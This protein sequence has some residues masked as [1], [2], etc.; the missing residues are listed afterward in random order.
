VESNLRPDP[1]INPFSLSSVLEPSEFITKTKVDG[2]DVQEEEDEALRMR[3]NVRNEDRRK[4][5]DIKKEDFTGP[6]AMLTYRFKRRWSFQKKDSEVRIDVTLVTTK[7]APASVPVMLSSLS[8]MRPSLEVEVEWI[9]RKRS[10]DHAEVI[11]KA[12][13]STFSIIRNII[14]DMKRKPASANASSSSNSSSGAVLEELWSLVEP[15]PTNNHKRKLDNARHSLPG[16]KPMTLEMHHLDS[17]SPNAIIGNNAITY[18]VTKKA[19]GER[20]MLFI[21]SKRAGYLINDRLNVN[22]IIDR[23]NVDVKSCLLDGELVKVQ[24]KAKLVFMV[25]DAY[26]INGINL[27]SSSSNIDLMTRIESVKTVV[28]PDLI[29]VPGYEVKVKEFVKIADKTIDAFVKGCKS[30]LDRQDEFDNDGLILTP[31]DVPPP[32]FGRWSLALKWKPSD[33]N[34]I[35]F[36]VRFSEPPDI[37]VH[38]GSKACATAKLMAGQSKW[39]SE[40]K[41]TTASMLNGEAFKRF[42]AYN[43]NP[44]RSDYIAVPFQGQIANIPCASDGSGPVANDGSKVESGSVVEF[45]YMDGIWIPMRVRTDK[46][47]QQRKKPGSTAANNMNTAINVWRSIRNPISME[48]MTDEKELVKAV[49]AWRDRNSKDN[50]GSSDEY[51]MGGEKSL[52]EGLAMRGMRDF[53]NKG[54]KGSLIQRFKGASIMDMGVGRVGDLPKWKEVHAK[55]ILGF[56]K[57][58]SNLNDPD[59]DRSSA[60]FRILTTRDT[61]PDMRIVCIAAD[62]SKDM[63]AT[64]SAA[65]INSWLSDPETDSEVAQ[66]LWGLKPA[67]DVGIDRSY[68]SF[69]SKEPFQLVTCMFAVHYMFGDKG[70]LERFARNVAHYLAPDGH[71]VGCCLDGDKVNAL[72]DKAAPK[73]GDAMVGLDKKSG[74]MAWR[75]TREYERDKS[76]KDA[77]GRRIQVFVASIGQELPEFLVSY[78]ELKRVMEA[79]GLVAVERGDF[80]EK[81]P[82]TLMEHEKQYSELHIWFAFKAPQHPPPPAKKLG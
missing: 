26:F 66:V 32:M 41:L 25:F 10:A 52:S 78:D 53:H 73:V 64:S 60:N 36:E 76:G 12:L 28:K 65:E 5:A 18:T 39:I 38:H 7:T 77:Y 27:F 51:Y 11:L 14:V 62:V 19:D 82:P 46:N 33:K 49:Q 43:H 21:N 58:A 50:S 44:W 63:T 68:E 24:G 22:K 69:A 42:K 16:F 31:N 15:P 29:N 72:L 81:M 8:N 55:R 3:I 67:G 20:M 47:E 17:S 80:K 61:P 57:S 4:I 34:S 30:I 1:V 23:L 48:A 71:F 75:I 13:A 35:D 54:I 79:A 37:T 45:A 56:D 2:L 40:G 59:P 6:S 74:A 70:D 9:G